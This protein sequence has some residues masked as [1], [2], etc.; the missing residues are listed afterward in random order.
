MLNTVTGD[1]DPGVK[2]N[3]C[4]FSLSSQKRNKRRST[5]WYPCLE[6]PLLNIPHWETWSPV[7]YKCQHFNN[8]FLPFG[9][10]EL[11]SPSLSLHRTVNETEKC[12][13][14]VVSLLTINSRS[15]RALSP[16]PG[17]RRSGSP[18]RGQ[19]ERRE[20][21][22]V[23]EMMGHPCGKKL[24]TMGVRKLPSA[25]SLDNLWLC[26]HD[27]HFIHFLIYF[28]NSPMK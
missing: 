2:Q 21:L 13:T 16:V 23:W 4:T 24:V 3:K 18:W 15:E 17:A 12:M 8:Y 11:G 7:S 9:W 26:L 25:S 6:F 5:Y 27:Q 1:R 22:R 28:S 10:W 20:E 19:K 14:F